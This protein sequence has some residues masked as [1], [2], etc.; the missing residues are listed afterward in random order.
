MENSLKS[1]RKFL[2]HIIYV[3]TG[4]FK[5]YNKQTFKN[6]QISPDCNYDKA[7]LFITD[8]DIWLIRFQPEE[9]KG[10][11]ENACRSYYQ[12]ILD[13]SENPIK[14]KFVSRITARK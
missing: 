14:Y 8:F 3:E 12:L 2:F 10:Y 7:A 13:D 4:S 11:V 6:S 1:F 5:M 9:G